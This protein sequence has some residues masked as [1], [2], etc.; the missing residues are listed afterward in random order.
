LKELS[1]G[2]DVKFI[3]GGNLI[4]LPLE[5]T[6]NDSEK[7]DGDDMSGIPDNLSL[8]QLTTAETELGEIIDDSYQ[9]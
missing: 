2:S 3:S 9:A 6:R 7:D 4:L 5:D 1:N 8:E